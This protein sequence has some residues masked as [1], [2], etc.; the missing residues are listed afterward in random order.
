MDPIVVA[1]VVWMIVQI[2]QGSKGKKKKKQG[3]QPPAEPPTQSPKGAPWDL[4]R[5][6]QEWFPSPAQQEASA[7]PAAHPAPAPATPVSPAPAP[8]ILAAAAGEARP[9]PGK[10]LL[11]PQ[12][13]RAAVVYAEILGKPK[14][15]RGRRRH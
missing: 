15:L 9:L 2:V 12:A 8:P 3:R 14:A 11:D 7:I 6:L 13:A 10:E 5:M 1:I 4:D